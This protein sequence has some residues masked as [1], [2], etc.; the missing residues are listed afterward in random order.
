MYYKLCRKKEGY[1]LVEWSETGHCY[2]PKIY[3]TLEDATAF[4]RRMAIE[5]A[6]KARCANTEPRIEELTEFV[7]ASTANRIMNEREDV[8]A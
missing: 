6:K 3:A 4:M 8:N 2:A 5:P 1:W 7:G